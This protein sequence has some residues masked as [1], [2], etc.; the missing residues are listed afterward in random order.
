[1]RRRV[2][3]LLSALLVCSL[4]L[5][6]APIA[7]AQDVP[8]LAQANPAAGLSWE[9]L[10]G[11][12]RYDTMCA[13]A[14]ATCQRSDWAVIAS[15]ENFPDALA[16]SALAGMLGAPLL[17]TTPDGLCLQCQTELQDLQVKNAYLVG[18]TAALSNR[19][20]TD[21][22]A[23]G[24]SVIRIGGADRAETSLLMAREMKRLHDEVGLA[25]LSDT[26][27]V[28]NGSSFAGA[29]SVSPYAYA[30]AA[31][32]LLTDED[33]KLSEAER[34]FVSSEAGFSHVVLV[35]ADGF[36]GAMVE[37][38]VSPGA[39]V[40]RIEGEGAS[41][42]SVSAAAWEC[43]RGM[44]LSNLV[45]C[46]A[47]AFPD[48]LCAGALAGSKNQVLLMMD[49]LSDPAW[50]ALGAYAPQVAQATVVGG[51]SAT[52]IIWSPDAELNA[53]VDAICADYDLMDPD[54]LCDLY[55]YVSTFDYVTG[56]TY[57]EGDWTVWSVPYAI[58]MYETGEGNCY[59]YAS[60]MCWLARRMGWDARVISGHTLSSSGGQVPHAWVEVQEDGVARVIDP[61]RH[62]GMG[63]DYDFFMV[64][65]EEASIYYFDLNGNQYV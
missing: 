2:A 42:L 51:L 22:E 18:G 45:V 52:P 25:T 59:S 53:V 58:S 33:G 6:P 12:A 60:L 31:P 9:R 43:A 10:A 14:E 37:S 11:P 46:R 15:G 30:N 26:V 20:Q 61:E 16:A 49:D 35:C 3:S 62:H 19:V 4:A 44:G 8:L 23:S 55:L 13:V 1:M 17:I 36:T 47:S 54:A 41:G 27:F 32:I 50:A 39:S 65:Y 57:P 7:L 64:T 38:Q 40:E 29:L 24:I 48:A 5:S 21:A 34:S 28:T 63:D 56:D